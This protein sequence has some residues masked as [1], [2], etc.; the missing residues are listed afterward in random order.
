MAFFWPASVVVLYLEDE[1]LEVG[2]SRT[3]RADVPS[4]EFTNVVVIELDFV[5]NV[6]ERHAV[7]G[8]E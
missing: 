3:G 4:E 2:M 7:S 5:E 6:E 8:E 1:A